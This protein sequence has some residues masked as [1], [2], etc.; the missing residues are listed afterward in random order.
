M[1]REA[2][3]RR[4]GYADAHYMLGTI[5]RQRG[6]LEAA[7]AEFRE[8][9]RLNPSSAEAFR[10]IGQ[11]LAALKDPDAAAAALSDAER[12]TKA[13]A[14]AQAAVFAIN[15]GREQLRA[16]D[17]A[18]AIERFREAIHLAPDNAEAHYRLSLALRRQGALTEA[19]AELD[20]ARTL[21]WR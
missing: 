20:T 16:N 13:K 21:G 14:N 9:T 18:G 6:D 15:A 3:S 2:L 4:P 7:L 8:T 12:L 11:A 19:R 1:F 17:V 5:Y 10:S